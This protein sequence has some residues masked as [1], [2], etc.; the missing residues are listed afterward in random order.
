MCEAVTARP[1]PVGRV[2]Q[3]ERPPPE[4]YRAVLRRHLPWAVLA[5]LPLLAAAVLPLDRLP[6]TLCTFRRLTGYPCPSCGMT[7]AFV[8]LAH[9][10]WQAALLDCPMAILLYGL[11]ALALAVNGAALLC[12]VRIGAGRWLR[13]RLPGWLAAGAVFGCL[14][15]LNWIYRLAAGLE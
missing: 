6:F 2:F 11:A 3:V 1:A 7:R 14:G 12:G 13:W 10:R 5:A 15:L 9:G 8:A 4:G